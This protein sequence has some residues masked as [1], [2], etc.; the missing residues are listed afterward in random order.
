MIVLDL[1]TPS[2]QADFFTLDKNDLARVVG[3]L[4]KLR[5]MTWEQIYQDRGLNWEWVEH[6]D[7]YTV[8]A[9][10][11]KD[12]YTVR[13]SDKIRLSAKRDGNVIRFS[14]IFTDHDSAYN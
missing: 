6:K 5:Q 10:E 1:N 4:N 2:F 9:V 7:Y 3:T 13:A 14:R 11:H 12:Y 8:R